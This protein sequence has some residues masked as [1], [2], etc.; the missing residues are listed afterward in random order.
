V[1]GVID[2]YASWAIF[3]N[4]IKYYVQYLIISSFWDF[5]GFEWSCPNAW[6]FAHH[7]HLEDKT[8][9]SRLSHFISHNTIIPWHLGHKLYIS[10][11]VEFF[12]WEKNERIF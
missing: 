3:F 6:K 5:M 1:F 4:G 11:N 10:R 8:S 12:K 7:P 9:L 2:K